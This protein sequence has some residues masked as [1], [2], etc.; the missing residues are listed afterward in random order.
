MSWLCPHTE[1]HRLKTAR[2]R[3]FVTACPT[4]SQYLRLEQSIEQLIKQIDTLTQKVNLSV[5][6]W[7]SKS[8]SGRHTSLVCRHLNYLRRLFRT[9]SLACGLHILAWQKWLCVFPPQ[10]TAAERRLADVE[11]CECSR[12]CD[13]NG[14]HHHD[15]HTWS[16]DLCTSC[17]CSVS[18]F[19]PSQWRKVSKLC[20]AVNSVGKLQTIPHTVD[21]KTKT[22]LLGFPFRR[23]HTHDPFSDLWI[24]QFEP[25]WSPSTWS[26]SHIECCNPKR[27]SF[28]GWCH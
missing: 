26:H 12:G 19:V 23:S 17:T 8:V 25:F 21:T 1:K 27:H 10:L 15:G 5:S 9:T 4:C 14:V 11:N 2:L 6:R 24:L 3:P 20:S 18:P 22:N 7:M 16:P 28:N 13:F